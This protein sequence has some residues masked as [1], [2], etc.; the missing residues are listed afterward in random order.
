M[1]VRVIN[2]CLASAHGIRGFPLS[3]VV[4]WPGPSAV[5]GSVA[6][7]IRHGGASIS[8]GA[9]GVSAVAW[10]DWWWWWWDDTSGSDLEVLVNESWLATARVRDRAGLL[11]KP[12]SIV[13]RPRGE[14]KDHVG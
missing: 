1:Y 12:V 7:V 8:I 10:L 14:S 2:S 13:C 9:S 6:S 4:G 11:P 5:A 3:W